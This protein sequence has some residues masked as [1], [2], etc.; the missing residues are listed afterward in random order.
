MKRVPFFVVFLSLVVAGV[1][2]IFLSIFKLHEKF[3]N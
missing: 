2:F 3:N 1:Q